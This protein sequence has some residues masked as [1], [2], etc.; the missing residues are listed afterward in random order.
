MI[1]K[2]SKIRARVIPEKTSNETIFSILGTWHIKGKKEW[3]TYEKAAYL[4]KMFTEYGYDQKKIADAI[5]ESPKFVENHI[6]AYDLMVENSVYNLSK[7]SYF[8]ELVKNK[9]ICEI[10]KKEPTVVSKIIKAIKNEKFNKAENIRDLPKILND[11]VA[12]REIL[13]ED[14]DFDDALKTAQGRHP[15]HEDTFYNQ[16]KKT[17]HLLEHCSME[18]IEEIKIDTNKKYLL[19]SLYKESGKVCKKAELI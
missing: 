8:L 1:D 16:I 13:E 15:E 14:V 18:K 17:I 19:K 2:W 5:R 7:F 4:K 9:K 11:K 12:K 3:D 10:S 6:K